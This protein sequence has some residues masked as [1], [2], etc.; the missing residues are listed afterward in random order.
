MK[1]MMLNNLRQWRG[2]NL[3]RNIATPTL[4]LT[5]ERDNFFPRYVFDDVIKMIPNAEAYDVGAAKHKVQLE[6]HE[7]VN[8]AI[9]RFVRED[10]RVS[11][12]S[13]N[14]SNHLLSQRPW[15]ARYSERTP[16]TIPIPRQPVTRFLEGAAEW[17]PKRTATIFFGSRLTY[18]ELNQQADAFSQSLLQLGVQPDD[19]VMLVLPN[20]PQMIV[21]FYGTL[22]LGAVAV[23]P[24]PDADAEVIINQMQN[25]QA[26][27]LVTMRHFVALAQASL[28][29][30][31][32]TD[33]IFA[34]FLNVVPLPVYRQMVEKRCNVVRRWLPTD[35]FGYASHG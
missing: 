15:L 4:V 21:A 8:R 25:T 9:D 14:G 13:Q 2:W 31:G 30:T 24:N 26:K 17:L 1:R 18:K 6:R 22:K 12:R 3:L 32:V 16:H 35:R 27:V 10:N 19:R 23:L 5:G 29:Q 11:W 28:A 33:V 34:D 20:T 7:A